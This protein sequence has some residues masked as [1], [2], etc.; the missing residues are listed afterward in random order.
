MGDYY[1]NLGDFENALKYKREAK[2]LYHQEFDYVDEASVISNIGTL[3]GNLGEFDEMVDNYKRALELH[4]MTLY[5]PGESSSLNSLGWA[6]I[7]DGDYSQALEYQLKSLAVA[8]NYND[9]WNELRAYGAIGSIYTD[10]GDSLNAIQ[11]L[12]YYLETATALGSKETRANALN[13]LGLVYLDLFSDYDQAREYFSVSRDLSKLIGYDLG[14][15]VSTSNIGVTYSRQG[16]CEEALEYQ[17]EG[18]RIVRGVHSRYTEMQGLNEIGETYQALEMYDMALESHLE[19]IE[20]AKSFGERNSQWMY[21]FNAGK[22]FEGKTDLQNAVKYYKMAAVTLTGIKKKIKSEEM[23]KQFGDIQRQTEVYKRLIDLLIRTGK[24]D[25]AIK[26]IEESKSKIVK[27]AFGDIKPKTDNRELNVTLEEVDKIE[28]KREA[29]EKELVEEK[30]KPKEKQDKTKIDNLSSTLAST[31]GEFNQW[32]MKLKFQNRQMFDA[33]TIKPTTLGDVQHIIPENTVL[34]EYFISSDKIYIFCIGKQYFIAKSVDVTE[35]EITGLIDYYIG[36]VKDPHSNITEELNEPAMKLYEYL[37]KPVEEEI[38]RFENIVIV[39]FGALYYLPFHALVHEQDGKVE[40]LIEWKRI[41]YTTSATFADVLNYKRKE[42]KKLIA[43]GNPDGSLPSASEEVE[44]LRDQIFKKDAIIW[45]LDEATKDKFLES[46]KDY[47]VIHLATH[48]NMQSNPLE[49]YLLFAGD[50]EDEQRLTLL[51]V[52]GYTA[53]RNKTTLVFLSACQTATE[54]GRG[55][56]SELIS[57]AEAFAMAG[58]P[59][60][61]AT[62]WEVN[63]V[64]TSKLAVKFYH[65]LKREKKDKL[66]ALRRAQLALLKSDKFSHPFFWAPFLLI[67]SWR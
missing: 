48:G 1:W 14:P 54:E 57:L 20:I 21:E 49:S 32:M 52:A 7:G 10:L 60:L 38:S 23:K 5:Y 40:Y 34:L 42:I 47:D 62:L 39:P 24:P 22:A 67:G 43:M 29:L 56:G 33:L 28:K 9:R 41:S 51:E 8:R 55:T 11:Y 53:L 15:G 36:I 35:A 25:E 12:K 6:Y 63:D 50:T 26:Y 16:R 45:T 3:V 17:K 4:K 61:I 13:S 27:D 31:E 44:I 46:A 58:P 65:V 59:T 18:L 66:E 37:I 19:A 2:K 30:K 64:S